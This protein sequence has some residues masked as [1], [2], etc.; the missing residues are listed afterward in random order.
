LNCLLIDDIHL[1]EAKEQI[2]V[3]LLELISNHLKQP[4]S[5]LVVSADVAPDELKLSKSE[6]RAVFENGIVT[7]LGPP[8]KLER[9]RML[10]A[11]A[12]DKDIPSPVMEYIAENYAQD[13]R[14]L[15]AAIV[16][17]LNI[18]KNT[19]KTIDLDLARN[20]LPMTKKEIPST[21]NEE[22]LH[23]DEQQ[24][25]K[26]THGSHHGKNHYPQLLKEMIKS[27]ENN[28]EHALAQQIAISQMIT[29]LSHAKSPESR[30][31]IA[32]LQLALQSVRDGDLAT[33]FELVQGKG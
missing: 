28:D 24:D 15:K 33:A 20:V 22:E 23:S 17:L 18:S 14:E 29:R 10:T 21:T 6:L 11:F 7:K 4:V 2:Q 32:E 13:M 9:I 31:I 27:A 25:I 3:D 1:C 5:L 12:I 30:P 8:D 19:H 16:H 26:I